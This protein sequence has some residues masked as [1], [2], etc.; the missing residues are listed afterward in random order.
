[1]GLDVFQHVV[2]CHQ[3]ET[4]LYGW[5]HRSVIIPQKRG[6]PLKLYEG[7]PWIFCKA[8]KQ[9][10]NTQTLEKNQK[11]GKSYVRFD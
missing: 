7:G 6:L 8:L 4:L 10:G 1:M 3:G 11:A 2:F 9:T 5:D